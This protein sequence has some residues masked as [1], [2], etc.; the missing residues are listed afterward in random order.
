MNGGREFHLLTR[1][2]K[3]VEDYR[4][5]RRF[6][7]EEAA[8]NSARSWSAPALWR[9][10]SGGEMNGARDFHLLTRGGKAVEDYRTPRRFGCEEAA[11]N[12]ARSWSAPALWRFGSGGGMNGARN[13]HLLTRWAKAVEDY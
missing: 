13:F 2:A 4:T 6:A 3:A 1:G 8:G 12:S 5:P 7:S 10:G 11:G 9:F